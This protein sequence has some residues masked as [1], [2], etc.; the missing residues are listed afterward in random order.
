MRTNQFHAIYNAGFLLSLI[1]LIQCEQQ[2]DQSIQI[3]FTSDR[4]GFAVNNKICVIDVNGKNETQ[5]TGDTLD[6]YHPQFSPD[7]KKIVF[8]SRKFLSDEIW[9][10]DADGE[11]LT[12]L[13]LSPGTDYLPRF[14]PDGS[15]IVFVSNRDGN[16]EIYMMYRNGSGTQRLTNNTYTDFAPVF[17]PD[18][19]RIAFYSIIS[20]GTNWT[21][22]V[23][24][25]NS[26][27]SGLKRLTPVNTFFHETWLI[28]YNQNTYDASP[29]FSPDGTHI[30]FSAYTVTSGGFPK[31]FIMDTSGA[32][33]QQVTNDMDNV[34]PFFS[35]DGLYIY[36]R[37]HFR[38]DRFQIYRV[39]ID[40][41]NPINV[42][43][44]FGHAYFN[45]FIPDGSRILY[46][47][48][49]EAYYDIYIMNFDGSGK[50][51][52]TENTD[53]CNNYFPATYPVRL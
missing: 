50:I 12:N 25:I 30:A 26:D 51:K 6:C 10:I 36:F 53:L 9:S 11:N 35:P 13:T 47:T 34:A 40:G 48:N 43:N 46:S 17:S 32:N 21:Y 5:L 8:Y 20:Q 7:G 14:S 42:S 49:D 1:T 33:I 41:S 24:I 16:R 38:D 19:N 44:D 39:N 45:G 4:P 27:G 28:E 22:D 18:G 2:P 29:S 31:I 15:K 3:V 37:S 23:F 52:L